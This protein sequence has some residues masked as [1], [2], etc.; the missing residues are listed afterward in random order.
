VV[1]AGQIGNPTTFA[2]QTITSTITTGVS[3]LE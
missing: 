1:G 3:D 2:H